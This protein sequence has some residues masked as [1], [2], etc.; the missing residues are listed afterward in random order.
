[1]PG[2]ARRAETGGKG[3]KLCMR[4][5][6]GWQVAHHRKHFAAAGAVRGHGYGCQPV[7]EGAT[8]VDLARGGVRGVSTHGLRLD[9]HM[10]STETA[11]QE[12]GDAPGD[13]HRARQTAWA[14]AHWPAVAPAAWLPQAGRW[15]SRRA[16]TPRAAVA[17]TGRAGQHTAA[18]VLPHGRRGVLVVGLRGRQK[19]SQLPRH[20]RH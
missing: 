3:L 8:H 20:V 19:V 2:D 6:P 15:D 14:P 11:A 9:G 7:G 5:A 16:P 4:D 1:M 10:Q 13:R 12:V 17:A 18:S